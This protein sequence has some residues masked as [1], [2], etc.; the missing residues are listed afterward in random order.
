MLQKWSPF[1][2]LF[3]GPNVRED[4][5]GFE[6]EVDLPGVDPT[7]IDIGVSGDKLSIKAERKYAKSWGQASF[8][9][10]FHENFVLPETV[11]S[12]GIT[13][14]YTQGV[15]RVTVPKRAGPPTRKVEVKMG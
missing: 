12:E 8:Y 15:L 13:A 2:E 5:K 7:N 10:S 11:D 14:T 4:G 1:E 6:I 9:R 3:C